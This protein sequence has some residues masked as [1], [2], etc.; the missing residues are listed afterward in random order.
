MGNRC[1]A[2]AVVVMGCSHGMSPS[3]GTPQLGC[4]NGHADAIKFAQAEACMND[5]SVEFCIPA[6][7]PQL[8]AMLAAIS[9]SITCGTGGGRAGCARTPG[10]LLC[11]YPT[12]FPGQCLS[13]HGEMTAKTWSDMCTI[14]GLPQVVEIVPTFFE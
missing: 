6:S 9:P 8:P 13:Q 1:A 12:A 7:D 3:G 14:A 4:P 5:G 11:S 2:I 10:L